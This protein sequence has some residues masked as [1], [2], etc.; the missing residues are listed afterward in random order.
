MI[1][2]S[3]GRRFS[4][5]SQTTVPE[6]RLPHIGGGWRHRQRE[7]ASVESGMVSV[8]TAISFFAVGLVVALMAC[9]GVAGV[10]RLSLC[11]AVRDGARVAAIQGDNPAA[12]VTHS[13]PK[14]ANVTVSYEGQWVTVSAQAHL[15]LPGGFHVSA[16][17]CSAT[18]VVETVLVSH[19]R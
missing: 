12:A 1:H 13:F 9:V 19:T 7:G 5:A 8:E 4:S 15:N 6:V 3:F 17:Q 16:A 10:T 11:H 14:A 2:Y 18:T